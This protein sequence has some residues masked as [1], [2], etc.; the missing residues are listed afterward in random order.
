M[1][2][3]VVQSEMSVGDSVSLM[4]SMLSHC[5]MGCV[6]PMIDWIRSVVCDLCSIRLVCD[7]GLI[8]ILSH[9]VVV[10]VFV[11]FVESGL[12]RF[13]RHYRCL[14]RSVVVDVPVAVVPVVLVDL[15]ECWFGRHIRNLSRHRLVCRIDC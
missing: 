11:V 3:L 12:L 14:D 7:L 1:D 6:V 10:N 5:L 2:C 13:D 4:L 8:L 15:G 9:L